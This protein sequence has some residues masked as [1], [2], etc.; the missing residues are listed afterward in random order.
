MPYTSSTK[1]DW[2]PYSNTQMFSTFE[3]YSTV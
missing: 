2:S 1:T 3:Q